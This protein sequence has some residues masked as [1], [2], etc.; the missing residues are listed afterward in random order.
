[1]TPLKEFDLMLTQHDWYYAYSDDH[2]VW[3]AGIKAEKRIQEISHESKAHAKLFMMWVE[4]IR[5]LTNNPPQDA[6]SLREIFLADKADYL[7][8][9][10]RT[11]TENSK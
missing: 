3:S 1:M 6:R 8:A 2:R 11:E 7:E 5:N 10:S 9:L 4:H